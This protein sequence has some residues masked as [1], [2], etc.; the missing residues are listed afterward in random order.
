MRSF[1]YDPAGNVTADTRGGTAYAYTINDAGR[2][3]QVSLGGTVRA[4][5]K[6]DGGTGSR[7]GSS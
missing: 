2:I 6:Y 4:N 7:S 3:G 5:Y 1:S